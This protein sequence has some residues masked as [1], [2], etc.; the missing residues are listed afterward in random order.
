MND[1]FGVQMVFLLDEM[2]DKLFMFGCLTRGL[3]M[4]ARGQCRMTSSSGFS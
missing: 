4:R 3:R 1:E 2:M